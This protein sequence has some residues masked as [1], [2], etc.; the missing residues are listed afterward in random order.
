MIFGNFDIDNI[1]SFDQTTPS[2][3]AASHSTT[4]ECYESFEK[5]K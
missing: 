2:A 1:L 5:C 4:A 3:A